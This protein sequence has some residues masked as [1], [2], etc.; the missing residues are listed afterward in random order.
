MDPRQQSLGMRAVLYL[1]SPNTGWLAPGMDT[2]E[3]WRVILARGHLSF[4][5]WVAY[6]GVW[7]EELQWASAWSL[8]CVIGEGAVGL[9][10]PPASLVLPGILDVTQKRHPRSVA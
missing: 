2:Q 3:R 5:R 6:C 10:R 9:R 1:Q 8:K 4:L 7:Q